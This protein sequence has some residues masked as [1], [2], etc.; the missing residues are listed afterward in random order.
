MTGPA[1]IEGI[2]F[3]TADRA[4]AGRAPRRAGSKFRSVASLLV[5]GLTLASASAAAAGRQTLDV[6]AAASL[7][8][9]FAEIGHRFERTHPGLRVRLVLAGSQQLA[10][11]IDQGARA[12]VFAS[13]DERWMKEVADRGHLDGQPVTFAHNQLVV[14]VPRANPGRIDRL[15]DLTRRGLK[16]VLAADAVPVGRYSRQMLA[17]LSRD[18]AFG[19]EF[20]RRALANVVSEEENVKS[21]VAKVQLG[22][23]DAGIVYRSDV[24]PALRR[25]VRSFDIPAAANVIATY[26][27]AAL[28]RTGKPSEAAAFVALVRS[29]EG[30][31]VLAR[32]GLLPADAP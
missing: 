3:R 1:R 24:T 32:H 30:Q 28:R 7:G 4:C 18:P 12:D 5:A 16:L 20:A 27:I 8:N 10:S 26:P 13:A 31:A 17:N 25:H 22:E 14:I 2:H 19:P 11:Q 9:A 29:A 23:A 15:Q 6:F 21:V